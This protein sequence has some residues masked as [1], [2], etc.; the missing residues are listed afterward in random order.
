MSAAPRSLHA[1]LS[2]R[3]PPSRR[4]CGGSGSQARESNRESKSGGRQQ[5]ARAQDTQI[6]ILKNA[7]G[8]VSGRTQKRGGRT[9][10]GDVAGRQ[11]GVARTSSNMAMASSCSAT[12]CRRI[13]ISVLWRSSASDGDRA[14]ASPRLVF[15]PS[16]DETAAAVVVVEA[17]PPPPPPLAVVVVVVLVLVG[18]PGLVLQLLATPF[19]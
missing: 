1:P 19:P 10:R 12:R 3:A 15:P 2:A 5:A 6:E 9:I 14:I 7:A 4:W 17:P 13:R 8:R 11:R 16:D 18:R